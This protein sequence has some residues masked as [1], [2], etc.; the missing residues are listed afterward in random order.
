[1]SDTSKPSVVSKGDLKYRIFEYLHYIEQSREPLLVTDGGRPTHIIYPYQ[2]TESVEKVF[3]KVRGKVL[4]NADLLES[5]N[6]DW[7]DRS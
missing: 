2:S 7:E 3:A 1:M 4:Y 5:A 6:E